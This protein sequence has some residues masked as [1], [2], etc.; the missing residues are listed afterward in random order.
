MIFG[1]TALNRILKELVNLQEKPIDNVI[2]QPV[3]GNIFVWEAVIIGPNGTPY[4]GGAFFLKIE[5]PK[6]YPVRPPKV[7]F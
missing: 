3:D 7:N 2:A 4:E 5:F 1:K 6:D